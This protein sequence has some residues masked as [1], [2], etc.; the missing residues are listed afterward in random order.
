M[1]YLF[2]LAV[3]INAVSMTVLLIGLSFTGQPA[4]AADIGIVQG[5]TVETTA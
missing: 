1:S 4:L 3:L 5:V 2:P